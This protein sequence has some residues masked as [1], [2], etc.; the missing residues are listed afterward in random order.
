MA[1]GN[2]R[3]KES[4]SDVEEIIGRFEKISLLYVEKLPKNQRF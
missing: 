1:E 2:G 3:D 4:K